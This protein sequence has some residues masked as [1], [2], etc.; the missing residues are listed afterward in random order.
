MKLFA[1]KK[2]ICVF[3]LSAL[4]LQLCSCY[5]TKYRFLHE[6]S[7][8]VSIEIVENRYT[9]GN[10]GVRRDYQNVLVSIEDTEEFLNEFNDIPYKMPLYNGLVLSF[11]DSELGIK[12]VYGNGDY[13]ILSN[14]VYKLIYKTESENNFAVDGVMGFLNEE[15]FDALV[16]K[17]LAK[18]ERP[19]FFRMYSDEEVES[20]EIVDVYEEKTSDELLDLKY[21]T[22]IKVENVESFLDKLDS[23]KYSYT[24]Q[25][26]RGDIYSRLEEN[27]HQKA[28]K[29]I[30]KNGDY[31]IFRH[32]WRDI[33][34]DRYLQNLSP[35]YIGEFDS[36]EFDA[37][38]SLELN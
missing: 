10:D 20:I 27:E 15:E 13:E 23:L 35:G 7:D 5:R 2:S 14:G 32:N 26:P 37:I 17:Y 1:F 11:G 22:V 21:N 36:T 16:S 6:Q 25:E 31:E 9:V 33:Y 18:A 8:I 4:L 28:V 24:L 34:S 29:I 19:K 30:Y 38:L 3:L 12:F